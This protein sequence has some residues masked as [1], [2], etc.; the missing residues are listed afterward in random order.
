VIRN[1]PGT[2]NESPGGFTIAFDACFAKNGYRIIT[3]RAAAV[4]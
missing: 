2:A 3:R 4:A 1:K